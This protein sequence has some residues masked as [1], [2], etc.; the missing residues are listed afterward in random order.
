[1]PDLITL[2]EAKAFRDITGTQHDAEL[3]RLIKAAS[4][5]YLQHIDLGAVTG[6]VEYFSPK[7]DQRKLFL[8]VT[9][10]TAITSLYDDPL[11][12]YGASTLLTANTH[13]VLE[14][15]ELGIV[16]LDQWSFTGGVNSVKVTYNGG[17]DTVPD[18]VKQDVIEMVW[19]ARNKGNLNLIGVTSRSIADGSISYEADWKKIIERAKH[20]RGTF[21]STKVMA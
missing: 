11:R 15:A 2:S 14:H 12:V 20:R 1:M 4:A 10:V 9:P 8:S 17:F 7:P 6:K 19:L 16:T 13:Y 3:A 18:D 21:L 5:E